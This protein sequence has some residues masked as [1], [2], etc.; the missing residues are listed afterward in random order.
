MTLTQEQINK[1]VIFS[2]DNPAILADKFPDC[3][4]FPRKYLGTKWL[5]RYE[6]GKEKIENYHKKLALDTTLKGYVYS[7]HMTDNF[8][9]ALQFNNME[10]P[11][12]MGMFQSH[13]SDFK[14]IEIVVPSSID[15]SNK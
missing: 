15:Q 11:F 12:K 3:H 5:L 2:K 6:F 1:H 4:T 10:E 7:E 13:S 8:T 9:E 14:L